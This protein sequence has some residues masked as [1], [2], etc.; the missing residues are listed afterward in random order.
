MFF[1]IK[2]HLFGIYAEVWFYVECLDF[3][4]RIKLIRKDASGCTSEHTLDIYVE[5]HDV[6]TRK[7]S[8]NYRN[9]N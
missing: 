7:Q 2:L 3:N 8:K 4:F 6:Y 5:N 1:I 9:D